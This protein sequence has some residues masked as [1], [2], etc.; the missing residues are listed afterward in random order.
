VLSEWFFRHKATESHTAPSP[1]RISFPQTSR[2]KIW[3]FA[4]CSIPYSA[5]FWTQSKILV[6][7][8]AWWQWMSLDNNL[9][10]LQCKIYW[11]NTPPCK[12][13]LPW[14]IKT[15]RETCCFNIPLVYLDKEK[16]LKIT[17]VQQFVGSVFLG[18]PV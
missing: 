13:S 10:A 17:V 16:R 11:W 4:L 18:S 8:R 14:F 1:T 15:C 5:S 12:M 2:I 6:F 9:L 3:D 7:D